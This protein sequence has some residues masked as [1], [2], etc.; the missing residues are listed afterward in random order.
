MKSTADTL[1]CHAWPFTPQLGIHPLDR[2]SAIAFLERQRA[3][4]ADWTELRVGYLSAGA[5]P[6]WVSEQINRARTVWLELADNQ[7]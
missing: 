4:G 1:F 3:A 5:T 7:T 2:L 6:I